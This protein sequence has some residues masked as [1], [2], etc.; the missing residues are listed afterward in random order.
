METPYTTT[1]VVPAP[2]PASSDNC[3]TLVSVTAPYPVIPTG[4][5][6]IDSSAPPSAPYPIVPTG[7]IAIDTSAPPSVPY[8]TNPTG[9]IPSPPNGTSPPSVQFPGMASTG[10]VSYMLAVAAGLVVFAL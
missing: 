6:A 4:G 9:A 3:T 8:P 10:A 1:A 2:P 5:I 7:G